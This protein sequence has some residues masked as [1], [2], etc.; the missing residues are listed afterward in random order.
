MRAAEKL[1]AERG[2]ENVTLRD[3]FFNM[4]IDAM[5]GLLAAEVSAQTHTALASTEQAYSGALL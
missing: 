3:V 4:L 1:S 2:A 5:A